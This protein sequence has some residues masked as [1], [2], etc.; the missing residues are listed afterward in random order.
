MGGK[1]GRFDDEPLPLKRKLTK[2]NQ[3]FFACFPD[4]TLEA[5]EETPG[6][7]LKF[8]QRIADTENTI[9]FERPCFVP[10]AAKVKE[11]SQ[12]NINGERDQSGII[13]TG[14]SGIGK[15]FF[16]FYFA[17]QLIKEG[18]IVAFNYRN[19]VR[20]VF[21]PPLSAL[22]ETDES[23]KR[24]FLQDLLDKYQGGKLAPLEVEGK[25]NQKDDIGDSP[26]F[27]GMADKDHDVWNAVLENHGTWLLVDLHRGDKYEDGRRAC[28]IVVTST[29]RRGDWPDLDSGGD[30]L[31][32]KLYMRPL[33]LDEAKNIAGVVKPNISPEQIEERFGRV[34]GSARLLLN[35]PEQAEEIVNAAFNIPAAQMLDPNGENPTLTSALVHIEADENFKKTGRK[36][37]SQEIA[38][39]CIDAV[40]GNRELSEQIWLEAT[41]GRT[42]ADIAGARGIFA[43]RLWHRT[44]QQGK[45]VHLKELTDLP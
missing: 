4:G 15:T 5:L 3:K 41:V 7:I 21:A 39:R 14:T 9:I 33:S 29:L 34:G 6:S 20:V 42:G 10:L 12:R 31:S 1:R 36:F 28:K 45:K 37:A 13:I 27:W 32:R 19:K 40:I 26:H 2:Q 35:N 23:N 30:L 25:S 18:E 22:R 43:E 44:V 8:S 38:N 16:G 11:L 17:H 24:R